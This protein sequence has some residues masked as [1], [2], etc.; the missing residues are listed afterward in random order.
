MN[1]QLFKHSVISVIAI[2]AI[3][4]SSASMARPNFFGKLQTQIGADNNSIENPF[5]QP[6]DP[7][8]SGGN[9]DQTMQFGDII[10]GS[11]RDDLQIGG[12]GTDILVG[13]GG[14]DVII[15]GVEH[16]NPS[17]RDRAFGGF[18]NDI[19]IWKPGDG[20]DL[21]NGGPG[22]DV[23]VFGLI[24]EVVDGNVEFKVLNDQKT[25]EVAIDP[26]TNLP[27][28]DVSNSPGF[29][30]VIDDS[31][32]A[33]AKAELDALNLDHL[34]RFSLRKQ[35]DEFATEVQNTDNGL[36]VTLHLK[37]VEILVCTN[38]DGGQI[39]VIDLTSTPPRVIANNVSVRELRPYIRSL[40][41][42]KRLEA[43]I[44]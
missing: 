33:E 37:S 5:I 31:F 4:V 17:N 3:A 39:E 30:D 41:L 15:G 24:G 14:S 2:S 19:F 7:A 18:G 22:L 1:S 9:R 29:C 11:R 27:L 28:V 43:M 10:F 21:W 26:T 13:G 12:L 23:V 35:A 42:R 38:R 6:Q 20:S 16:F 34:V 8:L 44:F 25:G 40:R 36:R 32:S